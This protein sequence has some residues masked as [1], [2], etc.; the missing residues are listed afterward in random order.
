MATLRERFDHPTWITIGG[1]AVSYLV[2]LA[3]MT[4]LLFAVPYLVFS[5]L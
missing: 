2:I 3:I 5:F 1:T 4:I